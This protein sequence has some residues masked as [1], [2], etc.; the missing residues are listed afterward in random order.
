MKITH[1]DALLTIETLGGNGIQITIQDG[2]ECCFID[3]NINEIKEIINFFNF[4]GINQ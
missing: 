4:L 3:L 1:E 2:I